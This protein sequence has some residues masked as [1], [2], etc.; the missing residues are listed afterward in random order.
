MGLY[1]TTSLFSAKKLKNPWGGKGNSPLGCPIYFLL[2]FL[3]KSAN[4]QF[5]MAE[6]L[7]DRGDLDGAYSRFQAGVREIGV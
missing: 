5:I 4:M 3:R 2:A 6:G 1:I 7:I